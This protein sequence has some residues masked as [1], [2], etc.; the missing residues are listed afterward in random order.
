MMRIQHVATVVAVFLVVTCTTTTALRVP[1]SNGKWTWMSGPSTECSAPNVGPTPASG[2]G[3]ANTL[4]RPGARCCAHVYYDHVTGDA[5]LWGGYGYDGAGKLGSL[6]DLWSF[7]GSAWQHRGGSLFRDNDVDSGRRNGDPIWPPAR[8]YAAYAW[9]QASRTFV[10]FSGQA[11]EQFLPDMWALDGATLKW[12]FLGN[13]SAPAPRKWSN[14][15]SADGS[16]WVLGGKNAEGGSYND[17]WRFRMATTGANVTA[18][19]AEWQL[20][21]NRTGQNFGVYTGPDAMPGARHNAFT[22]ALASD[23]SLWMFGGSG[24]GSEKGGR[25]VVQDLWRFDTQTLRWSFQGGNAGDVE[26][27]GRCAA[28]GMPSAE[29]LPTARHAGMNFDFATADGRMLVFGGEHHPAPT[30]AQ[31]PSVRAENLLIFNDLWT[32]DMLHG[33]WTFEAGNC[34]TPNV[35]NATRG[36]CGVPSEANAP[37]SRYGGNA[38]TDADGNAWLFGGGFKGYTNDMWRFA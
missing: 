22:T 38:W 8:S 31:M 19:N 16:L 20:V 2:A 9:D 15:W 13:F 34:D 26:H 35:H 10:I 12:S 28:R 14:F 33:T 5:I 17:M 18:S 32:Y 27:D 29:A 23:Q 11:D 1:A 7:N 36:A 4:A 24:W 21:Y 30:P 3:C 25:G 37:Q 6:S